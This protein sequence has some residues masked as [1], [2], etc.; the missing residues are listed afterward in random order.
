LCI[1]NSDQFYTAISPIGAKIGTAEGFFKSYL[2]LPVV[3]F[4]WIIGYLWK[5]KAWLRTPQIDV[6]TGRRELDWD[7]INAEKAREAGYPT[8]KRIL[9]RIF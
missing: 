7:Y 2:A 6:D 8:W 3:I 5:R 1:A 9:N 4:F